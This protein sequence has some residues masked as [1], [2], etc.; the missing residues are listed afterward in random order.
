M[1]LTHHIFS[2]RQGR[3]G[4]LQNILLLLQISFPYFHIIE[5]CL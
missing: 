2:K 1:D 3:K 5:R 4:Q